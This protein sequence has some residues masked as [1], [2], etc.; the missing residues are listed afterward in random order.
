MLNIICKYLLKS[1]RKNGKNQY[2]S[3]SSF[4]RFDIKEIGDLF[5]VI[6]F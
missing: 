6:E 3:N 5:E 4:Q 1:G 2:N